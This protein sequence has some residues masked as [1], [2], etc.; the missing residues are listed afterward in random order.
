MSVTYTIVSIEGNIGSGKSTLLSNLRLHYEN[1]SNVVFLKEPVDDWEPIT[2]ENGTTY[3]RKNALIM[4][5]N[6]YQSIG[7]PLKNRYNF[8]IDHKCGVSLEEFVFDEEKELYFINSLGNALKIMH[9]DY[10]LSLF[11]ENSFIIGGGAIFNEF[12]EKS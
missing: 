12:F 10:R 3:E 8:V 9:S 5:Y 4:G 11:I 7:K 1:N 2:D 6:T